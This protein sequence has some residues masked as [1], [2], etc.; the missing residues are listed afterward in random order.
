MNIISVTRNIDDIGRIVL[1]NDARKT[2]N[3]KDTL[4]MRINNAKH[5]IQL[6][7]KGRGKKVSVAPDGRLSI[8]SD[9]LKKLNW[10][11]GTEIG[12]FIQGE[13]G[14]LQA[15]A[16]SCVICGSNQTLLTVKK[17]M[18]CENCLEDGF[19]AVIEKW[20]DVLDQLF[21]RYKDRCLNAISSL[22]TEDVHK[23]RTKGRRLRTLIHFIGL[24]RKHPLYKRLKKA[25]DVL[26]KV[27]EDDVLIESFEKKAETDFNGDV[28][29]KFIKEAEKERETHREKLKQK[30]PKIIDEQFS[31]M[32]KSFLQNEL[33]E[34]VF[35]MDLECK[36]QDYQNHFQDKASSY[37]EV[38]EKNSK[39]GLVALHEVRKEAKEIRYIYSFLDKLVSKDFSSKSNHYKM[40]HKEFG[41]IID[42]RDWLKKTGK[43]SKEIDA[44]NADVENVRKPLREELEK[45]ISEVDL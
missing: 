35:S 30:L 37:K 1:P 31:D 38:K 2:L 43:L 13:E 14:I 10:K 18:I 21:Q 8:P 41:D 36:L 17:A 32:W 19:N 25:H 22:D 9:Y 40:I 11:S 45:L 7:T 3:I 12:L 23:A 42:L 34:Y 39:E 5:L 24:K 28:Y 4:L 29:R 15:S 44:K 27:R 20:A 16:P 6:S 26:G 33:R